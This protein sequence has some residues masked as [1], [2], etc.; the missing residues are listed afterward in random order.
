MVPSRLFRFISLLLLVV[1]VAV[2]AASAPSA[3]EY[4][5]P[6]LFADYSDPD[7]IRHGSHFYLVSSTFHFSPGLPIL[8]S[9]DLVHWR[10]I[11]H[12]LPKLNLGPLYN[13][14]GGNRYGRGVWAPAIRFHNGLFYVYFPTPDE[15]IFVSTAAKITGPWSEP[16]AV[17]AAPNLEDPCPFW[18]DDGQAYLV[19]SRTGA[20]PLILHRMAPDG[21]SVLDEGKIIVQDRV[22]LPTLEGPKFYK[23]NGY[24]YIFAPFGG[25]S[26]GSQVVLRSK[27]IWGPYEHRV[28]LAKGNTEINGPHQGGYVETPDGKGWFLHFQSRG[29][30][31]RIVHLQPVRWENDWPIMGNV[32]AGETIGQPFAT[33]KLPVVIPGAAKVSPQTSDEFASSTLGQQWEWNHNPVDANWSLTKRPGYLRLTP[34]FAEDLF[35]AR[36]TLTQMMEDESMEF[37]AGLDI[38]HMQDGD[39]A[40]LSMFDRG[41]SSIAV[42]QN[43]GARALT[44]TMDSKE[45]TGS[46]IK[47]KRIQL[48][49]RLEGEMVTYLYSVDDGHSFQALGTPIK[50]VFSWWKGARPA[51]FA[52]NT[53]QQKPTSYVDFDWVHY[54]S[55]TR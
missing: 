31:G 13:M 27:N 22:N 11:A 32:A 12:V 50:A 33:Y 35:H 54:T 17:I 19:H 3:G 5:N 15:G 38:S 53:K 46:A 40:G 52:F 48:K 24:Y 10:I 42:V 16:T 55:I 4:G 21:K 29:A 14:E 7:V 47:A 2:W 9:E 6:I 51:L 28:V 20:G 43:G 8:E 45:Y 34:L 44:A 23:R 26:R 1:P 41:L 49:I 30:H 36:N 25:V 37:T 18:D 39:R